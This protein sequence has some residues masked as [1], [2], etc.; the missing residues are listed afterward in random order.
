MKNNQEQ[1]FG[2]AGAIIENDGKILMV[3]EAL[4]I[5]KDLW[6]IPAGHIDVGEDPSKSIVREVKEETGL[7]FTPTHILGVYSSVNEIAS[8]KFDTIIHTIKII[9]V[10]QFSD[11]KIIIH[12]DDVSETKWFTP[13]EINNMDANIIRNIDIKQMVKDYYDGKKYPLE[14]LKHV[15]NK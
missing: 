8:K 9:F 5:A 7:D 15:V 4:E 12:C 10:G 11:K 1:V 14:L 2:V 6:N 3:R 13:K